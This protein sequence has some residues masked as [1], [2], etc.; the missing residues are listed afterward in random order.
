MLS[1]S[2]RGISL[3]ILS[4]ATLSFRRSLASIPSSSSSLPHLVTTATATAT[5]DGNHDSA[6]SSGAQFSPAL[7]IP[8][9][10][11]ID[12]VS[13]IDEL[14][15]PFKTLD[16]FLFC[17]YHKDHYPAGHLLT[18]WPTIS[19]NWFVGDKNM[20]APRQGNG[21][22]FNPNQPY[23]MYHG[24]RIPGFPQHPHRGFETVTATMGLP[25]L[26]IILLFLLTHPRGTH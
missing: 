14:S 19:H 20:R 25:F 2:S 16:P 17:V 7:L 23:R 26:L 6:F 4:A 12:I 22:D 5:M 18:Q 11:S 24:D 21:A 10:L 9:I 1:C 13:C 3:L 15:F 8:S